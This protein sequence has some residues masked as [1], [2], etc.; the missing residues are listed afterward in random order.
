MARDGVTDI[1]L[2]VTTDDG[3]VGWG[4]ACSGGDARSI[5][6]AIRAKLAGHWM[7]AEKPEA[8]RRLEMCDECRVKDMFA[9]DLNR[10]P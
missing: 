3:L 10:D 2:E 7:Y 8:V 6:E 5:L 1:V 9:D 4:E